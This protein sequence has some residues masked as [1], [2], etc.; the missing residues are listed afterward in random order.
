MAGREKNAAAPAPI[1]N[2]HDATVEVIADTGEAIVEVAGAEQ[3]AGGDD[4]AAQLEALR[5][6]SA[7]KDA[8]IERLRNERRK[9]EA[10][11]QDTRLTVI[12][13][14]IQTKKTEAADIKRQKIEAK[15]KGD[16]EAETELD[17][18]LMQLNI[19]IRQATLGKDRL[20]HEIEERKAAPDDENARMEKYFQE[21]NMGEP[22]RR[23]LREHPEYLR[24]DLLNSKLVVADKEARRDGHIPNSPAYFEAIEKS[25]GMGGAEVTTQQ[26]TVETTTTTRQ[27]AA[28]SAPVSRSSGIGGGDIGIPGVQE[29][30]PGKWKVTAEIMESAQIAGIT[31]DEWIK[32]RKKLYRGSDGQLH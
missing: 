12:E 8:E 3:V 22:S 31:V 4:A 11:V 15:E 32:Q 28:P 2:G 24:D 5:A 29:L 10:V 9:D 30:G 20:S 13:Q 7:R 18:K 27:Q 6:E 23:W 17:D 19:D 1:V 16:Y 14:V 25:L 26:P 21:T